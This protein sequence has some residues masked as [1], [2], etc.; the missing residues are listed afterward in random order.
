MR[1]NQKI[2]LPNAIITLFCVFCIYHHTRFF[3]FVCIYIYVASSIAFASLIVLFAPQP[4]RTE[5][6]TLMVL[7]HSIF[8]LNL[9]V[10]H[11]FLT[12]L[13]KLF[14]FPRAT[15]SFGSLIPINNQEVLCINFVSSLGPINSRLNEITVFRGLNQ[16]CLFRYVFFFLLKCCHLSSVLQLLLLNLCYSALHSSKTADPLMRSATFY[17][18]FTLVSCVIKIKL[19][20]SKLSNLTKTT[21]LHLT[22]PVASI[23]H[24]K[25][26]SK[27]LSNYLIMQNDLKLNKHY[28]DSRR[29][30]DLVVFVDGI[31]SLSLSLSFSFSFS[32]VCH[33][34]G[35]S[36]AL[37]TT[38]YRY[39]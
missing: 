18:N 31:R 8:Y 19:L 12:T 27:R 1:G 30:L 32:L 25:V 23:S 34:H 24:L 22:K 9:F 28:Q 26:N 14:P 11:C 6:R 3:I 37:L 35:Q 16:A 2:F 17:K 5:K 38:E 29:S 7:T 36:E 20:H 4:D 10:I 21:L 15:G 39:G 13:P 33:C